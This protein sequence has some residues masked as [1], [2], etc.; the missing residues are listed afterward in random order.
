MSH[1]L[2]DTRLHTDQREK[3]KATISHRDDDDAANQI[4]IMLGSNK[5][6]SNSQQQQQYGK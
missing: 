5:N 3:S 2:N 4:F 6:Y 1:G